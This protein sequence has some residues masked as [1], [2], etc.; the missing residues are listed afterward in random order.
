[1][2]VSY[3]EMRG[4]GEERETLKTRDSE[5][6]NEWAC[7]TQKNT[8]YPFIIAVFDEYRTGRGESDRPGKQKVSQV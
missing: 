7:V 8:H 4:G 5:I 6:R 2:K 3:A 1:M